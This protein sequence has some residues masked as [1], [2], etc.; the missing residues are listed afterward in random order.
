MSLLE[1]VKYTPRECQEP[2]RGQNEMGSETSPETHEEAKGGE[3]AYRL[4]DDSRCGSRKE[5]RT[6]M[7]VE[8]PVDTSEGPTAEPRKRR[9]QDAECEDLRDGDTCRRGHG[10]EKLG[11]G[12][13]PKDEAR[14]AHAASAAQRLSTSTRERVPRL[15]GDDRVPSL[16]AASC[17]SASPPVSSSSFVSSAGSTRKETEQH[18]V[19]M[20]LPKF[21]DFHLPL[22]SAFLLCMHRH[23]SSRLRPRAR[24]AS[25]APSSAIRGSRE[26]PEKDKLGPVERWQADPTAKNAC[27][28]QTLP[29][30]GDD[31]PNGSIE[32]SGCAAQFL[33]ALRRH[34]DEVC[35]TDPEGRLTESLRRAAGAVSMTPTA[36]V[37]LVLQLKQGQLEDE[38]ESAKL[39]REER[40]EEHCAGERSCSGTDFPPAS[41]PGRN[42]DR[43]S[44]LQLPSAVRAETLQSAVL[45]ASQ[46]AVLSTR[47]LAS[48]VH[49]AFAL[50]AELR[51]IYDSKGRRPEEGERGQ[52]EGAEGETRGGGPRR[53]GTV[54]GPTLVDSTCVTR[55]CHSSGSR[56]GS[57]SA[58]QTN[59]SSSCSSVSSRSF[60]PFAVEVFALEKVNGENAQI[61]F[62]AALDA[63]CVCSK[64]VSLLVPS[65]SLF[66]ETALKA[67]KEGTAGTPREPWTGGDTDTAEGREATLSRRVANEKTAGNEE[68]GGSSRR[69]GEEAEKEGDAG[70]EDILQRKETRYQHAAK[71]VRA[72]KRLLSG[73]SPHQVASLKR[74]LSHHTIVGEFVG[75]T[76]KQHFL[77]YSDPSYADI[78]LPASSRASRASSAASAPYLIFYA[79]VP[80]DGFQ[81]CLPPH[82]AL[83]LL[84]EKYQ[85]P[86]ARLFSSF[87]ASSLLPF[88]DQ[89]Q[90]LVDATF[91]SDVHLGGVGEGV[92]LY[93]TAPCHV[94]P[95]SLAPSDADAS[96]A[97]CVSEGPSLARV[98]SSTAPASL[99]LSSSQTPSPAC[100]PPARLVSPSASPLCVFPLVLGL[101][102]VKSLGYL[103]RRR[104]R[105]KL[106]HA[107]SSFSLLPLAPHLL[108][109]SASPSFS[110]LASLALRQPL[111]SASLLPHLLENAQHLSCR[112]R[113]R[114][115]S[116][117]AASLHSRQHPKA[118]VFERAKE[119]PLSPLQ[120]ATRDAL[121]TAFD[122]RGHGRGGRSSASEN[123]NSD[124]SPDSRESE[125]VHAR[126]RRALD[127]IRP[128][129][130]GRLE[131]TDQEEQGEQGDAQE[132][133]K[134]LFLR[135]SGRPRQEGRTAAQA[136]DWAEQLLTGKTQAGAALRVAAA[137]AALTTDTEL[138]NASSLSFDSET[139]CLSVLAERSECW[140]VEFV[141]EAIGLLPSQPAFAPAVSRLRSL[142]SSTCSRSS[143]SRGT[144][145]PLRRALLS[146]RAPGAGSYSGG[147]R[148]N[149]RLWREK[150]N[151][152]EAKTKGEVP[153]WTPRSGATAHGERTGATAD[154]PGRRVVGDEREAAEDATGN[155]RRKDSKEH[156]EEEG[157]GSEGRKGET[158][159]VDNEERNS[160][161]RSLGDVAVDIIISLTRKYEDALFYASSIAS[162]AVVSS[163][164]DL[165]VSSSSELSSF[166]AGPASRGSSSE[167]LKA[168]SGEKRSFGLGTG[169][170]LSS[171]EERIN[172]ESLWSI[173]KHLEAFVDLRFL[174]FMN[175]AS[176]FRLSLDKECRLLQEAA[177]VDKQGR[178]PQGHG[179]EG[180]EPA[181]ETREE[182]ERATGYM[183]SPPS[184]GSVGTTECQT[185]GA[186]R[187]KPRLLS[188]SP[189]TA[190]R[191]SRGN[192]C[193][194]K[195]EPEDLSPPLRRVSSSLTSPSRAVSPLPSCSSLVPSSFPASSVGASSV[196]SS[197]PVV[198][199]VVPP[200]ALSFSVYR[201]LKA[202]AASRGFRLVVRH[203]LYFPAASVTDPHTPPKS[204][205]DEGVPR[206]ARCPSPLPSL[207]SFLSCA[208]CTS[209]SPPT[210]SFASLHSVSFAMLTIVWGYGWP[211][212]SENDVEAHAGVSLTNL[213]RLCLLATCPPVSRDRG[214][215][216]VG[217]AEFV[218]NEHQNNA[219]C[220]ASSA[221]V[222]QDGHANNALDPTATS[223]RKRR[224]TAFP[225]H[226]RG[227]VQPGGRERE[228]K[229]NRWVAAA[230]NFCKVVEEDGEEQKAKANHGRKGE[231]EGGGERHAGG[232]EADSSQKGGQADGDAKG[233]AGSPWRPDA[234]DGGEHIEEE[235]R[236]T[237]KPETADE[238]KDAD[239]LVEALRDVVVADATI[240][241]LQLFPSSLTPQSVLRHAF[242][243]LRFW[244]HLPAELGKQMDAAGGSQA[245]SRVLRSFPHCNRA[246]QLEEVSDPAGREG[247]EPG[248]SSVSFAYGS[249]FS[250][251]HSSPYPSAAARSPSRGLPSSLVSSPTVWSLRR[252]DE[253]T[254]GELDSGVSVST[255]QRT[256]RGI[257]VQDASKSSRLLS[258]QTVPR[259]RA[260]QLFFIAASLPQPHAKL[261]TTQDGESSFLRTETKF[262][263]VKANGSGK[264]GR[265]GSKHEEHREG[266]RQ[267]VH[268]IDA[269]RATLDDTAQSRPGKFKPSVEGCATE[270]VRK[271]ARSMAR[272]HTENGKGEQ[273]V[274]GGHGPGATSVN[275]RLLSD[276]SQCSYRVDR[277]QRFVPVTP[278]ANAVHFPS[279]TLCSFAS[280]CA[281]SRW[282]PSAAITVWKASP[283][284]A[285]PPMCSLPQPASPPCVH[286]FEQSG[287]GEGPP[288]TLAPNGG[289]SRPTQEAGGA[290]PAPGGCSAFGGVDILFL[291]SSDEATGAALRRR[292]VR[293]HVP[294]SRS[295]QK[296]VRALDGSHG[297]LSHPRLCAQEMSLSAQST[298]NEGEANVMG[299]RTLSEGSPDLRHVAHHGRRSQAGGEEIERNGT[300]GKCDRSGETGRTQD[301]EYDIPEDVFR[302]AAR[303][304]AANLAA[305]VEAFFAQLEERL[306]A[307]FREQ[308]TA[309]EGEA[310]ESEGE[311]D[312]G[313]AIPGA[314]TVD[315]RS[316]RSSSQFA[317]KNES[318]KSKRRSSGRTHKPLRVL[319]LIDK[320]FPVDAVPKQAAILQ[321]HLAVLNRRLNQS[322]T[323]ALRKEASAHLDSRDA[324]PSSFFPISTASAST[325]ILSRVDVTEK[326][327]AL[328][329][330]SSKAD[331]ESKIEHE[332]INGPGLH[333]TCTVEAQAQSGTPV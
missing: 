191:C 204:G 188:I 11:A 208:T 60:S 274:S 285:V 264:A 102:K 299:A 171:L 56:T 266:L 129:V 323:R 66:E 306:T 136:Q 275:G 95:A 6:R 158:G 249:P 216:T 20:G 161:L 105:E 200:L 63:W 8:L 239:K 69:L 114:V 58:A 332:T 223:D 155:E 10:E 67:H 41:A 290:C 284:R 207:S 127:R 27:L 133:E 177:V 218:G 83:Q 175:E 310:E 123:W 13:Q 39:R 116:F 59:A 4:D 44:R 99:P 35:G 52:N 255:P 15:P 277:M 131:Q 327:A 26:A 242:M 271:A 74:F 265:E 226:E 279:D 132:D 254:Q 214:E 311:G 36:A 107:I 317:Q 149:E 117:F 219:L 88:L 286:H 37:S 42:G 137:C 197:P 217:N 230:L 203:C 201:F 31:P 9:R 241:F 301:E 108:S 109:M 79:A 25:P 40:C 229:T 168:V 22:F 111:S 119:S 85:L 315:E 186:E 309:G 190:S 115:R 240:R 118:D 169:C 91:C 103:L 276:G 70:E 120:S 48:R 333:L 18:L 268:I 34:G 2:H 101:S 247:A 319:V 253:P 30:S 134:Q 326:G 308:E 236:Q 21:F 205:S 61:S 162:A 302:P 176:T 270:R 3:A 210:P 257:S 318:P 97:S 297:V 135:T 28:R 125:A 251:C 260:N 295:F 170:L 100:A 128:L 53:S 174:D 316:G 151:A 224:R 113:R 194:E 150:E 38:A 65:E 77:P 153:G 250:S 256:R 164:L 110:F 147:E 156:G 51:N 14:T 178:N 215:D 172:E 68:R 273:E 331:S 300:A 296:A 202:F 94:S 259:A 198:C 232:R 262:E 267:F 329:G 55:D 140:L 57:S 303:E 320:N 78:F 173:L 143:S 23:Q 160:C 206:S 138:W 146:A 93:F 294:T 81:V 163:L 121:G 245:V 221:S 248:A 234:S 12:E 7:E 106:R 141:Q 96:P 192:A 145:S 305:S 181:V 185:T 283:P 298:W 307:Y 148:G 243:L 32:A 87:S 89:L 280:L 84:R 220:F 228:G 196:A 165:P 288:E 312:G 54:E 157:A 5:K 104:I 62:S 139:S 328:S 49:A 227:G 90:G 98:S 231:A 179:G 45:S 289:N 142:L 212:P 235:R 233:Q 193:G 269:F 50:A 75:C 237:K 211:K 33:G 92:V 47:Q 159:N 213:A 313:C 209:S 278:F 189:T 281:L 73:R 325:A 292:G 80:H 272:R 24:L 166:S 183:P 16:C 17:A 246:C 324:V 293:R 144:V 314:S 252:E 19:R 187:Q 29:G 130:R 225:A 152:H 258:D 195:K 112:Q 76:V 180:G 321:R 304:G 322:C 238:V 46:T 124:T 1:V 82:A 167:D 330:L 222:T 199:L 184:A 122:E 86:T 263:S 182:N 64:N 291:V 287:T 72:W 282:C 126:L 71:V 43:P 244:R 154:A 261:A